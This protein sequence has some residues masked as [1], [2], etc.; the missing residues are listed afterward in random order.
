MDGSMKRKLPNGSLISGCSSRISSKLSRLETTSSVCELCKVS[1]DLRVS[2]GSWVESNVR[3]SRLVAG[4]A[5][6]TYPERRV[7]IVTVLSTGSEVGAED[8]NTT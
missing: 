7:K 5:S 2:S 4:C 3:M 8:D 6:S 1:S